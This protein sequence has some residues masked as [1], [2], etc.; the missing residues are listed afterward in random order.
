MS[1]SVTNVTGD[2]AGG[3]G[4]AGNGLV[5]AKRK[6]RMNV[7]AMPGGTLRERQ[8]AETRD[9]ILDAA[10]D[11]LEIKG[12]EH[13]TIE[14]IATASGISSRTFFRYFDSKNAVLFDDADK[15]EHADD[16]MMTAMAARPQSES[17]TEA[18][19]AVLRE[20]LVTLF[21]NENGRKL[22][23]LRIVL[24]EPSLRALAWDSFH[25]HGPDLARGFAA[26]LGKSADDLQPRVLA[27]AFTEAIWV[28]LERWSAAGA[29]F[30]ALP[31]LIDEA[32]DAISAFG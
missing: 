17:I 20:K 14:D 9:L 12:Y 8:R 29:Q 21:E 26:R 4:A 30:D 7:C 2:F 5:T 11:Q 15:H 27:A 3:A 23:Q 1:T 10:L 25:E 19:R 18:L 32:F 31:A 24:T 22:R 16:E 28:I 6:L 13:T